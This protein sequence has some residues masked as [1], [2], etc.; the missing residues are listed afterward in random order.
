MDFRVIRA[1]RQ[2][3]PNLVP[4]PR[5]QVILRQP[6]ANFTSCTAHHRILVGVVIGI[7]PENLDPERTLL[8][9]LNVI[10]RRV[11]HHVPQKNRTSLAR[12]ELKTVENFIELE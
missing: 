4:V 1:R 7:A 6:L 3:D 8:E 12:S 10:L 2:A 11:L 9:Q 5:L